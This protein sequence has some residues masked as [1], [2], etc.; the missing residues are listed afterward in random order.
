MSVERQAWSQGERVGVAGERLDTVVVGGGQAGL[1]VGYHLARRGIPFVIL[2]ASARVGDAWRSRWDSL[3]LFTP[4]RYDGLDGMPFPG[5]G[6]RM[7]TKDEMADYLEAYAAHFDLPVRSGVRVERVE[8]DAAGFAV[9]TSAGTILASTVVV[10]MGSSQRPR[11][12]GFAADL[13]RGVTTLHSLDYRSP[14]Q[15]PAGDVLVVGAGN[16]GAEIALELAATHRVSLSG[17][18]PG[19]VNVDID[20]WFGRHVAT[21]LVVGLVQHRVLTVRTPMGRRLRPRA[22]EHGVPLIRT[23][24]ADLDRAGVRRVPRVVG[25]ERGRPL[26][27]DGSTLDVTSL[28]WCTGFEPGLSWLDVDV[29]D[30]V[31]RPRHRLGVVEEVPGLYVVGQDFL[32]SLSSAQ[33]HGVSRD[34]ARIA[35]RIAARVAV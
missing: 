29:L 7:P 20:S 1:A 18:F 28:V 26:L 33:V 31:G 12:P 16:S 19:V 25:V 13:D 10:A 32:Y 27:A 30:D 4:A 3:R 35:G 17:E 22:L 21:R 8:R 15:V 2:D 11:V 34:A 24:P 6:D 23:S 9:T 5:P 14:A